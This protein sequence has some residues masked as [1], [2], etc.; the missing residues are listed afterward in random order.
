[1]ITPT[2]IQSVADHGALYAVL[3]QRVLSEYLEQ[4]LGE[5][6]FD[7][8]LAEGTLRF[9][10]TADPNRTVVARAHVIASIAPGPRSILWGW[11]HP[12]TPD[13]TVAATLRSLGERHGI[14]DLLSSEVAFTTAAHGDELGDD[15]AQLAHTIAAAAVEATGMTPYYSVPSGGGSRFVFLLEGIPLRPVDLAIDG[16]GITSALMGS[17]T[18]DQRAALL[19]LARHAGFGSTD[20]REAVDITDRRGSRLTCSFDEQNRLTGLTMHLVPPEG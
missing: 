4:Q 13:T 11:A 5:F 3:G 1:M 9:T 17:V 2:G 6:R 19:G 7:V 15:I 12:Q 16:A 20:A 18:T 10:S 14:G 8:D